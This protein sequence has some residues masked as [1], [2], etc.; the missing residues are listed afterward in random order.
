MD[1]T[2]G[3]IGVRRGLNGDIEA[4]GAT[5]GLTGIEPVSG[6]PFGDAA[7]DQAK[8]QRLLELK[9][10][11]DYQAQEAQAEADARAAAAAKTRA[12][13]EEARFARAQAAEDKR[14][15]DAQA[16]ADAAAMR[17]FKLTQAQANIAGQGYFA[18]EPTTPQTETGAYG[19]E[20][21][22]GAG[23]M[24]AP[25]VI[26]TRPYRPGPEPHAQGLDVIGGVGDFQAGVSS[27]A[28]N[29][30]AGLG[31]IAS[32]V[33]ASAGVAASDAGALWA[34]AAERGGDFLG[35]VG[36]AV[37]NFSNP[38]SNP[39]GDMPQR[40][41][42]SFKDMPRPDINLFGGISDTPQSV[43]DAGLTGSFTSRLFSG[44]RGWDKD[45]ALG[46]TT[47]GTAGTGTGGT[48]QGTRRTGWLGKEEGDI[49][50]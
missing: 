35:N 24:G 7:A 22:P 14:A 42:Q 44:I 40:E 1:D 41:S 19:L 27:Q 50:F 33:G 18:Q 47:T 36:G 31:E 10:R 25:P 9:A 15:A 46:T 6:G 26:P 13:Q 23:A 49:S 5:S 30:G 43:G 11:R 12:I 48:R 29:V 34:D 3:T 45:K 21:V 38:F 4:L 20:E 8:T 16:A 2:Y 17:E 39:F 28:A 32:D 37:R